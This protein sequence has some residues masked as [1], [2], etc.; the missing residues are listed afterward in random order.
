MCPAVT[1]LTITGTEF[2]LPR[3]PMDAREELLAL[4]EACDWQH[5]VQCPWRPPVFLQIVMDGG[6][7]RGNLITEF[8][9]IIRFGWERRCLAQFLLPPEVPP[10]Q[11]VAAFVRLA[12]PLTKAELESMDARFWTK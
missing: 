12:D 8:D 3:L 9:R 4:A 7:R 1:G 5:D 11:A 2:G 6:V 10:A